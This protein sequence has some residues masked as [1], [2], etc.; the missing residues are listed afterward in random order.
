MSAVA[1]TTPKM[2][3]F[4]MIIDALTETA[5]KKGTTRQ[6]LAKYLMEKYSADNKTAIKKAME[7]AVEAEKVVQLSGTG[8]NGRFKLA[9]VEK[10]SKKESPAKKASTTGAKKV[11]K[12]VAAKPKKVVTVKKNAVNKQ[13]LVK[14]KKAAKK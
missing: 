8:M 6:A 2:K 1:A 9:K 4:D 14:A 3:Y 12:K 10:K 7:K 11:V 13:K 5:Q